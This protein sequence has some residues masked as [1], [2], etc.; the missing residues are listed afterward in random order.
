VAS[1]G[2]IVIDP[3]RAAFHSMML[4]PAACRDKPVVQGFTAD[5]ERIVN[6]LIRTRAIAVKRDAE[7]LNSDSRHL[8]ASVSIDA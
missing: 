8:Y 7:A 3:F 4:P 2:E 5:A 6:A 1:G